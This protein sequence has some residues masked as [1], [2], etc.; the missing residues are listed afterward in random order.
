[1]NSGH[2]DAAPHAAL[3]LGNLLAMLGDPAGARQAYRSA[4]DSGHPDVVVL[5]QRAHD[6]LPT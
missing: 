1:M 5:A 3:N 6:E 2:P 4:I